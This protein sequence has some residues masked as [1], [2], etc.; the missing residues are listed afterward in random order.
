MYRLTWLEKFVAIP[1]K[2]LRITAPAYLMPALTMNKY[3]L[4]GFSDISR[5]IPSLQKS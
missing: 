3:C 1:L 2:A 5:T 4:P